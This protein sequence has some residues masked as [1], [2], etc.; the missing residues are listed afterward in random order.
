MAGFASHGTACD[1]IGL[2]TISRRNL[3]L[4]QVEVTRA[5]ETVGGLQILQ[6]L[7]DGVTFHHVV[8]LQQLIAGHWRSRLRTFVLDF[9]FHGPSSSKYRLEMELQ[10][11]LRRQTTP[12]SGVVSPN[13]FSNSFGLAASPLC[14]E[15]ADD[16]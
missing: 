12:L 6:F 13:C 11:S 7:G 5:D 9:C 16:W 1:A 3:E 10:L 2:Q 4:F 8:T 14:E 15:G